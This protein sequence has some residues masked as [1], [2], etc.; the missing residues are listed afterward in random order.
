M[1]IV[2]I[3]NFN[4][5]I[6]H[7]SW[8]ERHSIFPAEELANLLIEPVKKDI[9]ELGLIVEQGGNFYNSSEVTA[10]KFKSSNLTV[11]K[12]KFELRCDNREKFEIIISAIEK[13]FMI[14]AETP[15]KAYGINFVNS[16][17]FN[18]DSVTILNKFFERKKEIDD[19][20]GDYKFGHTIIFN[21][22]GLK[23]TFSIMPSPVLEN[24]LEIKF[25]FHSDINS[26]K[27]IAE[28]IGEEYNKSITL[29]EEVIAQFMGQ[30]KERK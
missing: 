2:A 13:I 9:P 23:I 24:G 19:Y 4:P 17:T 5:S 21:Q 16:F 26:A 18:E 11:E 6:F 7:P 12:E 27:E 14:L 29:G 22:N 15:V 10:I 20:F 3:G 25:N 8:F 1:I 30:F 28:K